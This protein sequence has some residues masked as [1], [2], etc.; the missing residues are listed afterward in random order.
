M[1]ILDQVM[2]VD[3]AS[4]LWN[5]SPGHIKNLCAEDKLIAKKIGNTWILSK[6]Q[7]NPKQK[8]KSQKIYK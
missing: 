5:L 3:E 1:K 8:N 4:D 7:E 6:N 2:G